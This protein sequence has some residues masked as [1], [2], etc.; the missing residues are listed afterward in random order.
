MLARTVRFFLLSLLALALA[1]TGC[2]KPLPQDKLA[3]AGRWASNEMALMILA[4]GTVAYRRLQNG[5]TTSVNGPI[6]A[7]HG[8]NFEVGIGPISTMFVV[9]EAPHQVDGAWQMVVDGVRLT[10]MT[11]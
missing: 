5:A 6:K 9:S 4:D 7:F 10:R 3:Y 8:D 1:L 2:S 11:P